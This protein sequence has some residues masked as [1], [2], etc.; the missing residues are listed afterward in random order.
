MPSILRP[1][2]S[3]PSS[4]LASLFLQLILVI[5]LSFRRHSPRR[6]M[7]MCGHD[8]F[9]NEFIDDSTVSGRGLNI[10]KVA[11]HGIENVFS[12]VADRD[13]DSNVSFGHGRRKRKVVYKHFGV[14]V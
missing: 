5:S 7:T 10:F 13:N 2:S 8:R 14:Q 4:A 12:F 3:S 6:Q 11:D 9:I 1:R